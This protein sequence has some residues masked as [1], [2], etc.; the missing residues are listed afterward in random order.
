VTAQAPGDV[1]ATQLDR[2]RA[3][4]LAAAQSVAVEGQVHELSGLGSL[5]SRLV[6]VGAGSG[7]EFGSFG[8]IAI[9]RLR[10]VSL[11]SSGSESWGQ[12]MRNSEPPRFPTGSPP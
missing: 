10:K 1:G 11:L 12:L 8:G 5:G 9:L 4:V 3:P 6:V 7:G 2:E